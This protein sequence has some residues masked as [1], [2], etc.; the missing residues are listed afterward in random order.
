MPKTFTAELPSANFP[1]QNFQRPSGENPTA[2]AAEQL[3]KLGLDADKQISEASLKGNE[4][5]DTLTVGGIA[6][7]PGTKIPEKDIVNLANEIEGDLSLRKIKRMR[8]QGLVSHSGAKILAANAVQAA[9]ARRPGLADDY[10]KTASAFFGDFG[11]GQGT[12]DQTKSEKDAADEMK[13]IR[14][15]AIT[16]GFFSIDPTT[17]QHQISPENL[18]NLQ[19]FTAQNT[20]HTVDEHRHAAGL[21][22]GVAQEANLLGYSEAVTNQTTLSVLGMV[23]AEFAKNG[24][25][26]DDKKLELILENGKQRANSAIRQKVAEMSKFT[27]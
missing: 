24:Y 25:V 9:S 11:E 7:P 22:A 23:N 13:K 14:A 3:T 19:Q 10:R 4:S 17:G 15:L 8:E 26:V 20:K 21:R 5:S 12:L 18:Y 27:S 2:V 6:I 16:N 1:H